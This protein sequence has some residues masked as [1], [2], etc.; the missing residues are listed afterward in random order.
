MRGNASVQKATARKDRAGSRSIAALV[1][2]VLVAVL[3]RANLYDE[4][5]MGYELYAT[6]TS[7]AGGSA[8]AAAFWA[9]VATVGATYAVA[10]AVG[11]LATFARGRGVGAGAVATAPRALRIAAA[12]LAAAPMC[13]FVLALPPVE[14]LRQTF[15]PVLLGMYQT[16]SVAGVVPLYALVAGIV[17]GAALLRDAR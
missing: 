15:M 13:V 14:A 6:L 7:D 10:G 1:L 17:L 4:A 11:I 5:G 2:G 8:L 12:V 9:A 3:A 16:A